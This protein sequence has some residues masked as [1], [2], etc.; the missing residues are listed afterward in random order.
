MA[1]PKRTL[2]FTANGTPTPEEQAAIDAITDGIVMVRNASV[3]SEN[4]PIEQ[5]DELAG[6]V[7]QDYTDAYALI[8]PDTGDPVA[9]AQHSPAEANLMIRYRRGAKMFPV[10]DPLSTREL[11]FPDRE[12][13]AKQAEWKTSQDE[14][15]P[16]PN[17]A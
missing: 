17:P 8:N 13:A 4:E 7:P 6:A 2:F 11:T 14:P 1:Q 16:E 15:N 3:V 10:N 12:E 9:D 5:A